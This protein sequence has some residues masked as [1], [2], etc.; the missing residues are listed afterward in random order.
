MQRLSRTWTAPRWLR[1]VCLLAWLPLLSPV[2][3]QTDEPAAGSQAIAFPEQNLSVSL[4]GIEDLETIVAKPM[5]QIQGMWSGRIGETK[6]T[7]S[8]SFLEKDLFGFEEPN[9]VLRIAEYNLPTPTSGD[10]EHPGQAQFSKTEYREGPY[11]Y[12]PVAW[13]GL[14]ATKAETREVNHQLFLCGLTERVGYS[15]EVRTDPALVEADRAAVLDWLWGAIRY[16]GPTRDPNWTDEEAEARWKRDAPEKVQEKGLFLVYR[17]KYYIILTNI[18]KSTTKDFGKK[19]DANYE[20]I[21]E[22]FPFE[23]MPAQRL[24]PVF[25]FVDSDQ[26]HDWCERVFQDRR[27]TSAGVA[28][29]DVYATYHQSTLA[30]VHIHEATHQIFQNRLHLSG[31]G[32]WFQEGVAEYMAAT[33][34]DLSSVKN[35]V[36]RDAYK[37]FDKFF[38]LDSLL[39][40][41]DTER[42]TGGSDAGESYAQA[43]ALIEFARH[44]KFGAA[45]FQEFVHTMGAVPRGDLPAIDAALQ[46]V[47]QVDIAGFEAEFRKYWLARKK[48]KDL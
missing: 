30:P 34:G 33:P 28:F 35:L 36:K 1:A 27:E 39:D 31:G 42:V 47:Y 40:D 11:G 15:L 26:Y 29:G 25:Y 7:L 14:F 48:R 3:A 18:G 32:S 12:V 41:A 19:L 23:D 2:S 21:R 37:H 4:A 45:K 22:V 9:D 10:P 43:A 24:L 16:D 13:L 8:L 46:K 38:V 6:F 5:G 44:S 17:T 20:A